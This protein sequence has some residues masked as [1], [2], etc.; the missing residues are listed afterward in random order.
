MFMIILNGA[1]N[2]MV[3]WRGRVLNQAFQTLRNCLLG[4]PFFCEVKKHGKT[5]SEVT[6]KFY[7]E[8]L[9]RALRVKGAG[10]VIRWC[11]ISFLS[12]PLLVLFLVV[13]ALSIDNS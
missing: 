11:W 5:D 10:L 8:S 3:G 12:P 1:Q 7:S 6:G 13:L 4:F 9:N 2:N